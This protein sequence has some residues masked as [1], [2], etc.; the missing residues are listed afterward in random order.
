[1]VLISDRYLSENGC[2]PE[3]LWQQLCATKDKT[4]TTM[5]TVTIPLESLPKE[6]L[7]KISPQTL[8]YLVLINPT[9][10]LLIAVVVG[11]PTPY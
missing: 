5:L 7:D 3:V 8:K 4:K 10:L 6:L 9:I 1:M 11:V 2:I